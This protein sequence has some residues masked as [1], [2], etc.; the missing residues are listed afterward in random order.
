VEPRR[1]AA[2]THH[3]AETLVDREPPCCQFADAEWWRPYVRYYGAEPPSQFARALAESIPIDEG[4]TRLLDLGCGSGIVG[5]CALL[6]RRAAFVTF[7]D[8]MDQWVQGASRNLA[9]HAG[10]GAIRPSQFQLRPALPFTSLSPDVIRE[11]DLIAFNPPQLPEDEVDGLTR[12]AMI[13]DPV[14]RNFRSG[15]PSG[16]EVV[17]LFLDWYANLPGLQPPTVLVLSSFLNRWTIDSVMRIRGFEPEVIAAT[18]VPLRALFWDKAG[19]LSHAE[20]EERSL[21]FDNGEWTK[22]LITVRLHRHG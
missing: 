10:T 13:C 6:K 11:H 9:W 7:T 5:I 12:L 4:K 18:R 22:E 19:L 1:G 8:I 2:S 16:L 17:E 20:R 14:R 15:G 3:P 21:A